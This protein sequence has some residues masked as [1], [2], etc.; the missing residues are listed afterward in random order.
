[1]MKPEFEFDTFPYPFLVR[2]IQKLSI[3]DFTVY[4]FPR[5]YTR[6]IQ[7]IRSGNRCKEHL[8]EMFGGDNDV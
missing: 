2:N 6:L 1:M 3:T 8:R 4:F 5:E 7:Y